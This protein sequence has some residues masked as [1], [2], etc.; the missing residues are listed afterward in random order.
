MVHRWAGELDD[1]RRW[2]FAILGPIGENGKKSYKWQMLYWTWEWF[3][4][5]IRKRLP[6]IR[7]SA[8]VPAENRDLAYTHLLSHGESGVCWLGKR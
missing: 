4:W 6:A 7:Y 5:V 2:R 8:D 3:P 1:A